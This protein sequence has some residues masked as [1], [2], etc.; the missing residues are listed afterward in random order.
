MRLLRSSLLIF[1]V[2]ALLTRVP[3]FGNPVIY[4][5]EEFYLLVGSRLLHGAIPYVD[6]WDRKPVG[7]FLLYAAMRALGG[8]GV[9]GYQIIGTGFV[10]L[11]AELIR[12]I[13]LTFSTAFGALCAGL[14]YI[15]WLNLGHAGAGQS[16]IFYNLP[17]CAAGLLTLHAML[18]E[19]STFARLTATGA[20]VMLLMGVAMQIKYSALF[21]G[22]FFGLTFLVLAFRAHGPLR[23]VA[24][25]VMWVLI[26]LVP[27]GLVAFAYLAMG[28]FQDFYFAN[29]VSIFFRSDTPVAVLLTR[30]ALI[31]VV[32][33][34]LILCAAAPVRDMGSDAR[35][36][37][38][39]IK[40]WLAAALL[41]VLVF[42]TYLHHYLLPVLVPA[43]AAAAAMFGRPRFRVPAIAMLV[44]A[45]AVG[46]TMMLISL[47]HHG[48][49][50]Q[51]KTIAQAIDPKGCLYVYSGD[52]A[53]YDAT[54]ACIATKFAFPSHLS[55]LEE[56][57]ALGVDPTTE[58][59][60]I[61]ASKP[62][63]V[64]VSVPY[65]DENEAARRIVMAELTKDYQQALA[66]KLGRDA[67]AVFRLKGG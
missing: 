44:V 35:T 32:L 64:I 21:E 20:S 45:L 30:L 57:K 63:T 41:G 65:S 59:S 37:F 54:P 6:L 36:G 2:A 22:V 10:V 23:M 39:F 48:G 16:P 19:R 3:M 46:E 1:L 27:T 8:P 28:H 43:A 52:P 33:L 4:T 60:R 38:R 58:V 11:T 9:W 61:M 49:D 55:R 42:G 25:G 13:G 17:V 5:D 56:A 47:R 50:R 51:F 53:F 67:V 14:A 62:T 34:P 29:F 40:L 26:A 18:S 7:L 24:A 15:V 66:A 12:R 31:L